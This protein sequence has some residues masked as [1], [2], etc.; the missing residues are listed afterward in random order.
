MTLTASPAQAAPTQFQAPTHYPGT[1]GPGRGVAVSADFNGD[2][3]PDLAVAD[4]A[5]GA[6]RVLLNRGD[7]T[8]AVVGFY[9]TGLGA[10]SVTAADFN[11]DGQVDLAVANT[12][13]SLWSCSSIGAMPRSNEE[14]PIPPGFNRPRS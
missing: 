2:G 4:Y 7:G 6:V 14:R 10:G 11:G 1:G 8:F 13:D 12:L 5:A 3:Y 9:P